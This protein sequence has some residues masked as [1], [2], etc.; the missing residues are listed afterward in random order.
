VI[1]NKSVSSLDPLRSPMSTDP[2]GFAML[3]PVLPSVY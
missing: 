3:P 1:W 2:I